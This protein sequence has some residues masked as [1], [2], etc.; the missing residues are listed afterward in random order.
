MYP[1]SQ[2][3]LV[4][5]FSRNFGEI[6]IRLI[7]PYAEQS[8]ISSDITAAAYGWKELG[9]PWPKHQHLYETQEKSYPAVAALAQLSEKSLHGELAL[10]NQVSEVQSDARAPYSDWMY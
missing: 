4:S 9:W 2:A 5:S 7:V 8:C 3:S 1:A 10:V 6:V